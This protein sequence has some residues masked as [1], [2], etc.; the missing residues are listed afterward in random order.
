MKPWIQPK[1]PNPPE[2][3]VFRD[4]DST[5]NPAYRNKELCREDGGDPLEDSIWCEEELLYANGVP[6]EEDCF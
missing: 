3:I 6:P 1:N 4:N 5:T 2:R